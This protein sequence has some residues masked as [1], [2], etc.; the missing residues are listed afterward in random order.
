[1]KNHK[2]K[3]AVFSMLRILKQKT[4]PAEILRPN[5]CTKRVPMAILSVS[6]VQGKI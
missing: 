2:V 4:P 1:M 3:N 6:T 5:T